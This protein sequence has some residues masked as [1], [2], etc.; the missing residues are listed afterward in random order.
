M[1]LT[2]FLA[3]YSPSICALS[4]RSPKL[5][6]FHK[7]HSNHTTS[8]GTLPLHKLKYKNEDLPK[9][10]DLQEKYPESKS[11]NTVLSQGGCGACWAFAATG[12]YADGLY[13]HKGINIVG[14]PQYMMNCDRACPPEPFQDRC[15]VGCGG[16]TLYMSTL[17]LSDY[18][19][20][21]N[22]C[23]PYRASVNECT[24]KCSQSA[25]SGNRFKMHGDLCGTN[26]V[27]LGKDGMK[28]ILYQYG[29]LL[30]GFDSFSDIKAYRG[31]V[32]SHKSG[33]YDGYHAVRIVGWGEENG[34]D[35]WII[36]NSWGPGYG[37]KGRFR[38]IAGTNDC[39]L[40]AEYFF[41]APCED[42]YF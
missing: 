35:Y 42:L 6:P 8:L 20:I 19:I 18:G 23:C 33:S 11:L 16:G 26:R 27:P 7:L 32:Y 14:S 37:E 10:Y 15:Q 3:L 36:H 40:E 4:Y 21:E 31:G 34:V 2:L 24:M 38:M 41:F 39:K 9:F 17:Y 13:I 28:R 22:D 1:S 25:P 30:V 29:P 12:A 5:T